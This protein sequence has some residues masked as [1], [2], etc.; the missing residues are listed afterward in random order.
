MFLIIL[1]LKKI[2]KLPVKKLLYLLRY[3][4]DWYKTQLMCDKAIL[5]NGKLLNSVSDCYKDQEMCNYPDAL[6][7]VPDH[8]MTEKKMC[9]CIFYFPDQYKTHEMCKKIISGDPF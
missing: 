7:F 9:S 5:E 6:E 4:P 1:K 8:V 2:C 3:V